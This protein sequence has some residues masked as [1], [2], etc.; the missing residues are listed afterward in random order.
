MPVWRRAQGIRHKEMLFKNRII[1]PIRNKISYL[2]I[3][4]VFPA[5]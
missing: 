2:L 1:Y 4:D 3:K 5:P